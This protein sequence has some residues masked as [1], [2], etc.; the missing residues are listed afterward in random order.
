MNFMYLSDTQMLELSVVVILFL[1]LIGFI[2]TIILNQNFDT[3]NII[4]LTFL[5]A[6]WYIFVNVFTNIYLYYHNSSKFNF[7]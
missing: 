1:I 7:I 4:I 5:F 3:Q 2:R 6:I